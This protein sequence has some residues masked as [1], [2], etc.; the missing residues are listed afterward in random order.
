MSLGILTDR[1]GENSL[2]MFK[3]R[4]V[5]WLT[6]YMCTFFWKGLLHCCLVFGIVGVKD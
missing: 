6:K 3:I 4:I 1:K 5:R 2:E